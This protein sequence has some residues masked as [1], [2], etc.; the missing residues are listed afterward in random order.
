MEELKE[1]A[2]KHYKAMYKLSNKQ[3]RELDTNGVTVVYAFSTDYSDT[4]E[5]VIKKGACF[6]HLY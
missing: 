3:K 2:R 1:K 4:H 5:I 6:S